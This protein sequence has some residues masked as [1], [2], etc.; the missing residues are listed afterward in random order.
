MNRKILR[1]DSANS[2]EMKLKGD[3]GPRSP[4]IVPASITEWSNNHF[5]ATDNT[6]APAGC[7]LDLNLGISYYPILPATIHCQ[8]SL[9][10]DDMGD[11]VWSQSKSVFEF[12]PSIL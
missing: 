11:V 6:D 1:R 3:A 5:D 9:K 7:E 8:N 10:A 2:L 4:I 12:H